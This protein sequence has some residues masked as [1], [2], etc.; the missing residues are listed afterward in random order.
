M[1]YGVFPG[2]KSAVQIFPSALGAG[3][4]AFI[5]GL[6]VG[7]GAL[8][9]LISAVVR[10]M[11]LLDADVA[12]AGHS[13]PAASSR[14]VLATWTA[15]HRARQVGE[16]VRTIDLSSLSQASDCAALFTKND[17]RVGNVFAGVVIVGHLETRSDS[18][19]WTRAKLALIERLL[20]EPPFADK[21]SI[22]LLSHGNPMQ[23]WSGQPKQPLAEAAASPS[24]EQSAASR[25]AELMRSFTVEWVC[26]PESQPYF[27]KALDARAADSVAAESLLFAEAWGSAAC[28]HS[29]WST[30]LLE[31]KLAL[32]HL[33]TGGLLN[34]GM[35][36]AVTSLMQRG[37]LVRNP[38]LCFAYE[39]FAKFVAGAKDDPSLVAWR[40]TAPRSD[41]EKLRTPWSYPVGGCDR[42]PLLYPARRLGF[43]VCSNRSSHRW[44]ANDSQVPRLVQP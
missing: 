26:L 5:L 43:H 40:Q 37:V 17:P 32:V 34:P 29:I 11:F 9:L 8:G 41:W 24:P 6:G 15:V 27:A 10:R 44:G 4:A 36:S 31:E 38:T 3:M 28:Y 22:V 1:L 35:L 39:D 7:I 23:L 25:W 2:C 19:E 14:F 21:V 12:L 33:A 18:D 42:V 13:A 20:F 30:I 16:G